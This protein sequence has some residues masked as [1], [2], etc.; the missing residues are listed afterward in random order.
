MTLVTRAD[1][2][3]IYNWTPLPHDDPKVSGVPDATLVDRNEGYE[4]LFLIEATIGA[5]GLSTKDDGLKIE[6][7]IHKV[8]PYIRS[9]ASIINWVC[10]NWYRLD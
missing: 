8:P 9:Q 2:R 6:R 4:I 3:Q 7:L 5:W 10:K 1:L